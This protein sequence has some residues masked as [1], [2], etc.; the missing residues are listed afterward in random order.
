MRPLHHQNL[1]PTF[2]K[3]SAASSP[4]VC[5]KRRKISSD[6]KIPAWKK[7]QGD[8]GQKSR[9]QNSKKVLRERRCTW[10]ANT[11]PSIAS[12]Q[13]WT[14]PQRP[15]RPFADPRADRER[16]RLS[17]RCRSS[18]LLSTTKCYLV[19]GSMMHSFTGLFLSLFCFLLVATIVRYNSNLN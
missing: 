6:R 9:V 5:R 10:D 2:N 13:H 3:P 19:L 18:L 4:C 12:L 16:R 1:D 8:V 14:P 17:V 15:L 11:E 7:N